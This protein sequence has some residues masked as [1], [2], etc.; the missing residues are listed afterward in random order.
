MVDIESF[1][2][3]SERSLRW[4]ALFVAYVLVFLFA[5]GIIDL[6]IEMYSVFASGD[7][8]DPI[9]IIELI[10]IV[11]LLLIILEVHRTLIAIVREEPVVR[12]IIGVAIIAIA[13]QVI[14]FRVEDF[15][16]ANEALVSAAALIGLL[17][18]LIGGYFMVRY[19]E[20]SS[21]HER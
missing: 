7:F 21:P 14:S 1:I 4:L 5:I 16:T 15:A 12:I 10:E 3:P 13:R 11:L 2:K 19:L 9:A 18:V 8:T 17:I 20:V 6:L